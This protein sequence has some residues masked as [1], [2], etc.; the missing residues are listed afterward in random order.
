[1]VCLRKKV[2]YQ[3][4]WQVFHFLMN[5]RHTFHTGYRLEYKLAA[6]IACFQVRPLYLCSNV[7]PG[8]CLKNTGSEK[9][10]G[11]AN[12]KLWLVKCEE[13]CKQPN[14]YSSSLL[15]CV[16]ITFQL[17]LIFFLFYVNF[18]I[19]IQNERKKKTFIRMIS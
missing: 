15:T 2:T 7:V 4:D 16:S 13:H 3:G 14:T 12:V 8:Y 5:K 10:S 9:F 18:I 19:S 11:M 1:M 17:I 6:L